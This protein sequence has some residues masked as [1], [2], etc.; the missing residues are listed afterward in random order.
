MSGYPRRHSPAHP[1]YCWYCGD[2]LTQA[3]ATIDHVIPKSR[4]GSG[5]RGNTV[6]ACVR[7]NS[8]KDDLLLDEFR[9]W[10][11]HGAD[12]SVQQALRHLATVRRLLPREVAREVADHLN[13]ATAALHGASIVFAG[14]ARANARKGG[15]R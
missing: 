2:E 7:C 3:T 6:H 11:C 14:E 12:E 10:V 4:G 1:R 13:D 9:D 8:T 5:L 15:D